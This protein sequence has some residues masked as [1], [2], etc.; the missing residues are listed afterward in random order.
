MDLF[1]NAEWSQWQ[2]Q[3]KISTLKYFNSEKFSIY[4]S[5]AFQFMVMRMIFQDYIYSMRVHV[6]RNKSIQ[7]LQGEFSRVEHFRLESYF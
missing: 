5:W 6:V 1:Y 3:E 4:G 7:F 2:K